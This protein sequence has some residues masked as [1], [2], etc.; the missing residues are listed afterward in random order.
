MGETVTPP[1]LSLYVRNR[2]SSWSSWHV[3]LPA[4][5]LAVCLTP[6]GLLAPLAPTTAHAA[7]I[8]AFDAVNQFIGTELDTSQNKSNDAYG[9]IYPGASVPFGMVQPSPTTWGESN[10]NVS[11]KGGY[12]YTASLIRGFGLTRYEG[13]GCT[14][15]FGGYEFPTIPYAGELTGGVL[16]KS[17]ASNIKDY[18][19]PF[20]HDNET[21][22]PG[23]YGVK[24]DNGV[25]AEMTS[26]T[27]TAVSRYDFPKSGSSSLIL[28][29][30]GPN[31]RT[32]G[33]EVTIDPATRT[34]SGWM[35][36]VDVCDNGNYYKAYFS[37]TYDHDFA[38]YGTWTDDT[39]TAGSTHAV[40]SSEDVGVDYRH[41]T[42]AWLTFAQGAKVVATTGFSYVSVE[43]AALNSETEVGDDG[44]NDVR[45]DAKKAWKE[46]LGTVDAEGGRGLH[47][48]R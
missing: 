5:A 11:Q 12:E 29:V 17:P 18:Y 31:N 2:T 20:R 1:H 28:D 13:T 47:P 37:T 40:K 45:A 24:L 15:R 19:L 27:R 23:Y 34:V 43:N 39:M 36:G 25:E 7:E 48:D 10:P 35:Y 21:S 32:F 4:V 6:V 22:Q 41:D 46:A 8:S 30:S 44:F 9:N 38:A 42:G 16:P 26:S 3:R 14:G 33:S